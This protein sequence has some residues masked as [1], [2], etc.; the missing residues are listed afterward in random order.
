MKE[1]NK[2]KYCAMDTETSG[3]SLLSGFVTADFNKDGLEDIAG[4]N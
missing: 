3:L 1:D 2:L 4:F